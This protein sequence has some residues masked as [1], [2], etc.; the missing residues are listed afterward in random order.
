MAWALHN[1]AEAV[2][3]FQTLPASTQLP[4]PGLL[5]VDCG[6]VSAGAKN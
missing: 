5:S 4:I 3:L 2:G 1:S 6:L